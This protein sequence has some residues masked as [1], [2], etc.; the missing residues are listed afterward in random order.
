MASADELMRDAQ[1]AFQNI[2]F[3][4]TPDNR[5]NSARALSLAAKVVR[6]YPNSPEAS[7]A[8]SILRRL[9]DETYAVKF[10]IQH[11]HATSAENSHAHTNSESPDVNLFEPSGSAQ[12]RRE[13]LDWQRLTALVSKLP[14]TGWLI[15]AFLGII[16]FALFGVF[17]LIPFVMLVLFASPMRT[18]FPAK[19]QQAADEVIRKINAWLREQEQ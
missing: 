12:G 6:K 10:S 13:Q 1:Y 9:G 11:S 19:N 15:F 3:A 18:I 4:D 2:S 16:F 5:K 7:V 14:R 17:L 8:R